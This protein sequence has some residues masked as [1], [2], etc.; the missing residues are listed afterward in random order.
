MNKDNISK[1]ELEDLIKSIYKAV[2]KSI[3]QHKKNKK[4]TQE[5]IQDILDPNYVA[6]VNPKDIPP[7]KSGVLYKKNKEKGVKKLKKYLKKGCEGKKN[8]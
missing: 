8:K 1:K 2:W 3:S 7:S 5:I 6:E 4:D